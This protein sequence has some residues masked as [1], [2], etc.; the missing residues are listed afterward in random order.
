MLLRSKIYLII[1]QESLIHNTNRVVHFSCSIFRDLQLLH[2][3]WN[4]A[5]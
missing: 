5:T 2:C 1:N 4:P 3:Q